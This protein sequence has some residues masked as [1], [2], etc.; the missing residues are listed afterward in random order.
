MAEAPHSYT[1]RRALRTPGFWLLLF[2]YGMNLAAL[3]SVLA[4]AIP[5]ATDAS[6]SRASASMALAVNG[7][8][9]LLSKAVWG[10]GLQRIPPRRLAVTAFCLGGVGVGLM[11]LAAA[12]AS[13][14]QLF[15]GFFCY[16]FGFGGTIPISEYLWV[17]YFGR[18]H[19]GEIRGLAQLLMIVG[20]TAGPVLVGAGYDLYGNYRLAF[21]VII[22]VYLVGGLLVG[23]SRAPHEQP[24]P[25]SKVSLR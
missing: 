10:Y 24:R 9:N 20:P 18:A 5:F 16:G 4:H 25:E 7:L 13:P 1:S 3:N 17:S 2:G 8:G 19:I 6:F 21:M 12:S 15:A 11:L 23:L 14:V 22:A